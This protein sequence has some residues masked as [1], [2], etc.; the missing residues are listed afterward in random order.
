MNPFFLH[1]IYFLYPRSFYTIWKLEFRTLSLIQ[2]LQEIK[3]F[4]LYFF[5]FS[6]GFFSVYISKFLNIKTYIVYIYIIIYIVLIVGSPR[7]GL[8]AA[9]ESAESGDNRSR[10]E[11]YPVEDS[12]AKLVLSGGEGYVD[13]RIGLFLYVLGYNDL[14]IREITL[15]N[16]WDKE[17]IATDT[18]T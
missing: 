12:N 11:A 5:C 18:L 14:L 1:H 2:Q 4:F 6:P 3:N 8:S 7:K 16:Y 9:T 17:F 13:F 15:S 10:H